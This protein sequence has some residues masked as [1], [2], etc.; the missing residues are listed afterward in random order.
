MNR[1]IHNFVR[2]SLLTAHLP[3]S[4]WADELCHSL[5]PYNSFPCHTPAGFKSPISI[6]NQKPVDLTSIRPFGCLAW[7]K[8]P[9]PD[10]K[11]LSPKARAS[12][13]LSYYLTDGNGFCLWDLE[14]RAVI[15]SRE[16][17]FEEL[18]FPYGSPLTSPQPQ[19]SVKITW[20]TVSD[21][22]VPVPPLLPSPTLP[23]SI[24]LPATSVK[25]VERQPPSPGHSSNSDLSFISLPDLPPL[26]PS[27]TPSPPSVHTS[28]R[29]RRPPERLG[30]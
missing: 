21:L 26:P 20:P 27:P 29:Q 11:K 23:P 10:R 22:P 9:E 19:L 5:F 4:F 2:S 1:T 28:T 14:K 12:I 30:H 24:P 18:S 25:E 17:R 8:V 13:L 16:V 7:Y 15:K 3:K 6:L